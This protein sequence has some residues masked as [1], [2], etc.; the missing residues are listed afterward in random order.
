VI[1]YRV[2][3]RVDGDRCHRLTEGKNREC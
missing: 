2:I 1:R 3:A